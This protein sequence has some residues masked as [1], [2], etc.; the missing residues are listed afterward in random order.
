MIFKRIRARFGGGTTVDT[1]VHTPVAQPGGRL[2]GVVEIVG[3]EF[4]QEISYL[5]LTLVCRVEVETEDSEHQSDAQFARQVV[6]GAFT[7]HPGERRSVPF[8]IEVPLETPFNVVGGRDFP[9]V[10]L[11]VRTELEIAKSTDK[12]DYDPIRVE[13]LPVQQRVLGAFERVGCRFKSTDVERGHIRGATLPFYQELEFYP[14][15]A[16]HG[17]LNEVEVTFLTRPHEL[18]VIMEGDRRGGLFTEG[19]DR[20]LRLVLDYPT[21]D[22][23]ALDRILDE[24]L[25]ELGRRRGLFG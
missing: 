4:Q 2:E 12:G 17:S 23:P 20:V 14:P 24:Q 6:E 22:S 7:L 19:D 18:E 1:I 11:G 16:L 8:S 25:H 15:P 9:G 21:I 13:P 10:R 3:G 5:A